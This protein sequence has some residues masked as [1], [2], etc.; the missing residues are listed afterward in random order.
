MLRTQ[1]MAHIHEVV[2][3]IVYLNMEVQ[4]I[5]KEATDCQRGNVLAKKQRIDK[6]PKG[7]SG[8]SFSIMRIWAP[9][10]YRPL[11]AYTGPY[12]VVFP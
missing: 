9:G 11:E 4:K 2:I 7:P 1:C 5:D 10:P 3:S 12:R 6:G 8:P